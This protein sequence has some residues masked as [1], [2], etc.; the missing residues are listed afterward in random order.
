MKKCERTLKNPKRCQVVSQQGSKYSCPKCWKKGK[1]YGMCGEWKTISPNHGVIMGVEDGS[2]A[3]VETCWNEMYHAVVGVFLS[4]KRVV[5]CLYV[6]QRFPFW[7]QHFNPEQ[8]RGSYFW[9]R[10]GRIKKQHVTLDTNYRDG[11]S[12]VYTPSIDYGMSL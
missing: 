5:V 12:T 3:M 7:K 6:S 1:F 11:T 2:I 9:D 8:S 10:K 4:A